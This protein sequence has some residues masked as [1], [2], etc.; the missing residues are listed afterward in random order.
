[1]WRSGASEQ[2]A[3]LE[4]DE[5]EACL[6]ERLNLQV[7]LTFIAMRKSSVIFFPL[8]G[9]PTDSSGNCPAGTCVSHSIVKEN[10]FLLKPHC[11]VRGGG[12]RP[13]GTTRPL[14]FDV[15][16]DDMHGGCEVPLHELDQFTNDLSYLYPPAKRATKFLSLCKFAQEKAVRVR[17]WL[18]QGMPADE[19]PVQIARMTVC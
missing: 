7:S 11:G 13:S 1:M 6:R 5:I 15:L 2:E 12:S 3:K 17:K 8:Q 16:R 19:L 9:N 18:A 10:Q 14:L 4:P